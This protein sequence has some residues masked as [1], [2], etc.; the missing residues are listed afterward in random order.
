MIW[1]QNIQLCTQ[2]TARDHSRQSTQIGG[3]ARGYQELPAPVAVL[4]TAKHAA[5]RGRM[6]MHRQRWA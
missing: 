2:S 6:F 5:A 4:S 3:S 1:P